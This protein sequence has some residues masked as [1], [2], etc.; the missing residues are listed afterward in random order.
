MTIVGPDSACRAH[1]YRMLGDSDIYKVVLDL[2]SYSCDWEQDTILGNISKRISVFNILGILA[3]RKE[4]TL[5]TEVTRLLDRGFFRVT[6]AFKLLW[7]VRFLLDEGDDDQAED[8]MA[9]LA[10]WSVGHAS[11]N[12]EHLRRMANLG[13]SNPAL[14]NAERYDMIFLWLTL[15]RSNGVLDR[16][17]LPFD[18][19][20]KASQDEGKVAELEEL[21]LAAERWAALGCP[22]GIVVGV[23]HLDLSPKLKSLLLHSVV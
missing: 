1:A 17:I 3:A 16:I 14:A 10:E 11:K 19:F 9:I 23:E 13:V 6:E 7:E 4:L 21:I 5:S 12:A 22:L 8:L 15:A 2:S 20:E 18:G